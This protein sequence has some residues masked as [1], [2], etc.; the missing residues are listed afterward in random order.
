MDNPNEVNPALKRG[1]YT[2]RSKAERKEL[3][4][5]YAHEI[6][7]M[8]ISSRKKFSK[9]NGVR[10]S[11]LT[12]WIKDAPEIRELEKKYF[13]YIRDGKRYDDAY[14]IKCVNL[15]EQWRMEGE[16]SNRSDFCV[17]NDL[18]YKSFCLWIK[19]YP[20][21]IRLEKK[22]Y[23]KHKTYTDTMGELASGL[24][25]V[26][27]NRPLS[28]ELLPRA[29][30]PELAKTSRPS[31]STYLS[32]DLSQLDC[33]RI[34]EEVTQI[35]ENSGVNEEYKTIDIQEL[36]EMLYLLGP[37]INDQTDLSNINSE[38][39]DETT[40]E[41]PITQNQ[42]RISNQVSYA[43][44]RGK[45][46]I[47]SKDEIKELLMKYAQEICEKK[48][49]SCLKFTEKNGIKGSTFR[50]WVEKIP[51]LKK[52]ERMFF[53]DNVYDNEYQ[54]KKFTFPQYSKYDKEYKLNCDKLKT[55][56]NTMEE[57]ANSTNY[58]VSKALN[59]SDWPKSLEERSSKA[60]TPEL[61]ETSRPSTSYSLSE[62]LSQPDGPK[63]M[64]E[65]IQTAIHTNIEQTNT[66]NQ[67]NSVNE[68][69]AWVNRAIKRRVDQLFLY[70]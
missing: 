37:D 5:K 18:P 65:V 69:L 16:C 55:Y 63:T 15:Y 14:K 13:D 38:I 45:Y 35:A 34:I 24:E 68:I 66:Q 48:V 50:K 41:Q 23:E 32:E 22:I 26:P 49:N 3:L 10:E 47:R 53:K 2:I 61:A 59:D 30:T 36:N 52:L 43:L 64:K 40:M 70:R 54:L 7:E 6:R 67:K 17:K 21:I 12:Y 11:T 46:T 31:T 1:K 39:I 33:Q 58:L 51:E 29:K 28:E 44:K 19:E 9:E 42:K 4:M 27:T 25:N 62:P 56:T 20:K 60:K 57:P 8:K